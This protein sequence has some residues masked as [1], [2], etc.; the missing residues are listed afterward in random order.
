MRKQP[1]A[2]TT[3]PEEAAPPQLRLSTAISAS[4]PTLIGQAIRRAF[5]VD[6]RRARR[7]AADLEWAFH[8]LYS[9]EKYKGPS[10]RQLRK[11]A[12]ALA[13]RN[14]VDPVQRVL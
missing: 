6:E 11:Q 5:T 13:S 9:P 2:P 4:D 14:R 12:R 3:R 8:L 10:R 1:A 7:L